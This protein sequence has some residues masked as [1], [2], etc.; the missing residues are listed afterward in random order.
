MADCVNNKIDS[1]V[2]GLSF[3][4]EVCAKQ[5]PTL[6]E[7]GHDPEWFGLE[8]NSYDDFGGELTTL[9]RAPLSAG[10]RRKKGTVVDLDASGGFNQDFT[11]NNTTR[12][13]QGFF[14]ADAREKPT[15]YPINGTHLV[16]TAATAANDRFTV[17]GGDATIFKP[18]ML[19]A[20]SG[21]GVINAD[22]MGVFEVDESAAGYVGVT[23]ALV[24]ETFSGEVVI[25]AVGFQFGVGAASLVAPGDIATF[26]LAASPV[27]ATA[28]LTIVDTENAVAAETVTIGDVVYTFVAAADAAYEV[29]IGADRLETIANLTAT[30]NGDNLLTPDEH[31]IVA[32]TDNEDGTMTITARIAGTAFNGVATA[33]TMTEGS[34]DDDLAGGTGVSLLLFGFVP[35]EW[36]FVGGDDAGTSFGAEHIGFARIGS[37]TETTLVFD[38]TTWEVAAVAA[39]ALTIQLYFGDVIKDEDG[40]LVKTRYFQFE[41]TL[42]QDDDGTQAEYLIGSVANELSFNLATADKV[43]VD[44][45]FVSADVEYRSGAEGLKDGE[46]FDEPGEEA[47]NTSTDVAR[48]RMSKVVPG[49]SF[50]DAFFGY[51][52]EG[53]VTINNNVAPVK[54]IGAIGGIDVTVGRFEV[55]GELTA[56]FQNVQQNKSIRANEDVT[57]DLIFAKSNAGYI[58]DIPLMT[59]GGG[60]IEIEEN[61]PIT[62][63]LEQFAAENSNGYTMLYNKFNYLPDAAMP[64]AA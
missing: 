6:A 30:I 44:L 12:L 62:V 19:I 23:G 48:I 29:T 18:G 11:L 56:L 31:P 34:W 27:A 60:R 22:N 10:R 39:G 35:G 51:V 24:D 16:V 46:H 3:A 63:P 36:V 17:T 9:A 61:E 52:T 50:P 40:E 32:A 25:S 33:E 58:F 41:R 21:P 8:P 43:T 37:I 15:T 53:T 59:L 55:G 47:F 45:S 5:L 7:D 2:T 4:E 1:N 26:T 42:G 54:A 57:L 13:L 49:N 38:K 28:I 64:V 20:V 14:F